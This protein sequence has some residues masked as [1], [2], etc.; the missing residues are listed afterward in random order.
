M[1]KILAE[2]AH[3]DEIK[4]LHELQNNAKANIDTIAKHCGFSSQKV[5]RIIKRLE[6]SRTIWGYTAVTDQ[7]MMGLKHFILLVKRTNKPLD[8]KIMNKIDSLNLEDIASPIDVYIETSCYIHGNYDWIICFLAEDLNKARKFCDL[9][10]IEF[11]GAI[12]QNDIQQVLY[13]ARKQHIFNPD[14]K[15]LQNL[16]Q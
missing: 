5:W 4:I 11:P 8:K 7:H 13:C 14:R 12:Q 3:K 1:V 15:Q 16:M 9:L 10:Q 2:Q 6:N